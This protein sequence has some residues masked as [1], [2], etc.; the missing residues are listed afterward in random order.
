MTLGCVT[1]TTLGLYFPEF[2]SL[3]PSSGLALGFGKHLRHDWKAAVKQQLCALVSEDQFSAPGPGQ[4]C[5]LSLIY[6]LPLMLGVLLDCG[7]P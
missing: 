2:L 4:C 5:A 6:Q 1:T 3:L 7:L